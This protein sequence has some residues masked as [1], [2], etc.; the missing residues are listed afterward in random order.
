MIYLYR[1]CFYFI[2]QAFFIEYVQY[3]VQFILIL[4]YFSER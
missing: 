1:R 3:M 4:F 2:L